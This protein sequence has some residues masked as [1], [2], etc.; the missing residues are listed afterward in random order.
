MYSPKEQSPDAQ[1]TAFTASWTPS[2]AAALDVN[3][4][5]L[6][7]TQSAWERKPTY[8]VGENGKVKTV[9]KRYRLRSQPIVI[10]EDNGK[11]GGSVPADK[12]PG[13]IVKKARV[14][15]PVKAENNGAVEGQ[16]RRKSSAT[17][18]ER[19]K[20]GYR[21]K[22]ELNVTCTRQSLIRYCRETYRSACH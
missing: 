7:K 11:E 19:R 9:W 15:S 18:Y 3:N 5:P 10:P 2:K 6:K 21:R 4:L 22:L 1:G 17:R 12:S 16:G 14:G 8:S 20:S 13:R